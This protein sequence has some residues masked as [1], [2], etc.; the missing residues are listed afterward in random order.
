MARKK[1]DVWIIND[2]ELQHLFNTL[3]SIAKQ[4][5][6]LIAAQKKGGKLIT[7][8]TQSNLSSRLK[9]TSD[10]DNGLLKSVGM[11]AVKKEA[12]INIGF[13]VKKNKWRGWCAH[14]VESG[15]KTRHNKDGSNRG[16]VTGIHAFED[17]VKAK[18][19]AAVL[20]AQ[21]SIGEVMMN[22][23]ERHKKRADR[24]LKSLK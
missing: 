2:D 16:K 12:A 10:R 22:A 21:N 11:M 8:Q 18:G 15:T 13:R 3:G 7:K 24:K 6:V 9:G 4:R 5:N 20:I 17:A 14:V 19:D 23:Y 1:K